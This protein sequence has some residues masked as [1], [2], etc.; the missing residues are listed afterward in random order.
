[1]QSGLQSKLLIYLL[2]SACAY[3]HLLSQYKHVKYLPE[4]WMAL[5]PAIPPGKYGHYTN[6][7]Q[8]LHQKLRIRF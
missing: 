2:L 4:E 6:N 8:C 3:L 7:P 1:M 5:F